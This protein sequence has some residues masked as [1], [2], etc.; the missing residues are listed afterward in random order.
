MPL[1]MCVLFQTS[2]RTCGAK[3]FPLTSYFTDPNCFRRVALVDSV[4]VHPGS[5]HRLH[6]EYGMRF[7]IHAW[8]N[9]RLRPDPHTVFQRDRFYYKIK[10]SFAKIMISC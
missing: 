2:S 1:C 5:D 4:S 6:G 3:P 8:T 7:G 10:C 9:Y